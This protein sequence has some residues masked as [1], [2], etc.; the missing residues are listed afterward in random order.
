MKSLQMY[1][2]VIDIYTKN[3]IKFILVILVWLIIFLIFWISFALINE[4]TPLAI[5]INPTYEHIINMFIT[6]LFLYIDLL[7]LNIIIDYKLSFFWNIRKSL[8]QLPFIII[9]NIVYYSWIFLWTLAFVIPWL[10][11]AV[12]GI[13]FQQLI[14][15]HNVSAVKSFKQSYKLV[16]WKWFSVLWFIVSVNTLQFIILFI[17][18]LIIHK[19]F[20]LSYDTTAMI[21]VAV[22]LAIFYPM[23]RI[24]ITMKFFEL[25]NNKEQLEKHTANYYDYT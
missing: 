15:L 6:T 19:I 11:A 25:S 5:S 12:Y 17:F 20:L 10:V 9:W 24:A 8:K 18:F 13:F 7:I 1:D 22:Y 23:Y 16:K 14:I 3:F 2:S 21:I 4:F